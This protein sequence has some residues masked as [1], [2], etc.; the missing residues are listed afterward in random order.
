MLSVWGEVNWLQGESTQTCFALAIGFCQIVK[1]DWTDLTGTLDMLT[2][3]VLILAPA[4]PAESTGFVRAS[5]IH[6]RVVHFCGPMKVDATRT[7]GE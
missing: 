5:I 7:A 6:E 4:D 1:V 2:T 3:M